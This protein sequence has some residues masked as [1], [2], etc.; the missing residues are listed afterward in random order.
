M[1]RDLET[2]L[3]P[4]DQG[5]FGER[6]LEAGGGGDVG[7]R[8]AGAAKEVVVVIGEVLGQLEAGEFV[9][10]G[11]A[12]D[13]A[14]LD[15]HPQIPVGGALGNRLAGPREHLGYRQR[16]ARSGQGRDD[17]AAP[18]GVALVER[19]QPRCHFCMNVQ[20]E[21]PPGTSNYHLERTEETPIPLS[22]GGYRWKQ[23][24]LA[25]FPRRPA[26]LTE[27]HLWRSAINY[28]MRISSGCTS[29]TSASMPC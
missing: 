12:A 11:D 8:P 4:G 2:A 6:L 7:D 29:P 9:G 26:R 28:R 5:G 23:R 24:T 16:A 20:H 3:L 21:F 15:Q 17:G 1:A 27:A 19:R 25:L 14:G 13:D 10:P 22:T 18:G